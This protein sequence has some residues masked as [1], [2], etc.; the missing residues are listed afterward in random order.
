LNYKDLIES[1]Y[2]TFQTFMDGWLFKS[3]VSLFVAIAASPEYSAASAFITLIFIDLVTKWLALAGAYL[4]D[5]GTP[6]SGIGG[7]CTCF[8]NMWPAFKAGYISSDKMKHRFVGKILWYLVVTMTAAKTDNLIVT[9]GEAK[10]FLHSAWIYLALTE[11]SSILENLRDA[12]VEQASD[13][14]GFVKG[15]L[16]VLMERY[17]QK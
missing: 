17:K 1:V 9:A 14:L 6:V 12:G 3:S 2:K 5:Q 15:R 11:V 10:M 16:G 8:A 13:L 7:L 4:K